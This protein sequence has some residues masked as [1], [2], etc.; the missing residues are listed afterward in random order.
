MAVPVLVLL[1]LISL[2][3]ALSAARAMEEGKSALTKA[4][5]FLESGQLGKAQA[6][7][8]RARDQFDRASGHSGDVLIHLQSLVPYAGRTADTLRG[9]SD[10]GVNVSQAGADLSSGIAELPDGFDS[11]A[12]AK[13]RIQVGALEQLAPSV[14]SARQLLER[15]QRTA[16]GL[17]KSWVFPLVKD[18]TALVR[19]KLDTALPAIRS[20]D[21]LLE[22]LPEFAGQN[23]PRRYFVAAQNPAEL[24]GT[25]G[26]IGLYSIL[27]INKGIMHL[28]TFESIQELPQRPAAKPPDNLG[29]PTL[30]GPG[31]AGYWSDANTM[32]SPAIAGSLL[33][34]LYERTQ[35][36][37]LDG[38]IFIDPQALTYMIDAT[39]PVPSPELGTTLTSRSVVPFV[40]NKAYF[41]FKDTDER[42]EALGIA[43]NDVWKTFLREAPPAAALR[44]LTE[45]VSNRHIII[46][47]VDP[48]LQYAFETAGATGD[49]EA[50]GDFL[51]SIVNNFAGNKVDF[52]MRRSI[53]YDVSLEPNGFASANATLTFKNEAPAHAPPGY[54]LGPFEGESH[55]HLHLSPGDNHSLVVLYS[56]AGTQVKSVREN[57]KP[58]FVQPENES[59]LRLF[60]SYITVNAQT[61]KRLQYALTL[62]EVWRGSNAAGDYTLRI[63]GQPT[64]RPTLAKVTL[65]A[66]PGMHFTE[67]P[68]ASEVLIDGSTATWTGEVGG[69]VDLNL[70]FE[71]GFWGRTWTQITD[72]F[73]K[74][75][76]RL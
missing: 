38:T 64:I 12:P 32:A 54:A 69:G 50:K 9:L 20:A 34:T 27:T 75:L 29:V 14:A 74:P 21:A 28:D 3:P 67:Q 53:E 4:Q 35:G 30:F 7:F 73:S 26:L 47:A 59:D 57:G 66:P 40:T 58:S 6:E 18:A 36:V 68:E 61:S 70:H 31:V 63:Q 65:R 46:H 49:L 5:A 51:G 43:A 52:Y 25:G 16:T 48:Q 23:R 15:A 17:P 8:N 2:I 19:E 76:I 13:G 72:C 1:A 62:P 10:I 56:P 39:G 71:R 41:R 11:L 45:A 37:R 55:E 24:R 42:K 33:E 44:A 60:G 22:S